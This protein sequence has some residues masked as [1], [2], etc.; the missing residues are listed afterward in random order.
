LGFDRPNTFDY[1]YTIKKI[2][3]NYKKLEITLLC[4]TYLQR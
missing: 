2:K 4:W 3:D 1:S